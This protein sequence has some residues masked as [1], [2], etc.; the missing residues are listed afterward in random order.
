MNPFR[1]IAAAVVA[2]AEVATLAVC[3]TV[4]AATDK[5][6]SAPVLALD[7]LGSRILKKDT[8]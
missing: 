6:C 7:K 8:V 4:E 5:D 2:V 3:V 1:L